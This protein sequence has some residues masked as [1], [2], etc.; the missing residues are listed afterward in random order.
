MCDKA[1]Q[2]E[3]NQQSIYDNILNSF[4]GFPGLRQHLCQLLRNFERKVVKIVVCQVVK[5]VRVKQR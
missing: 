4:R 1:R 3:V 5:F 2:S